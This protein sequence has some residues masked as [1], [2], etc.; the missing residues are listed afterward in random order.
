MEPPWLVGTK[1]CERYLGHM[2]KM[3]ATPLYGKNPSTISGTNGPFST[4]LG[5]KH[6]GLGLII[7]CSNDDPLMILSYKNLRFSCKLDVIF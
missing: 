3:A 1:V 7:V 4:K 5:M 6:W 2:T